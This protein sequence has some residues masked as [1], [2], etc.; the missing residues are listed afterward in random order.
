MGGSADYGS[1]EC[2]SSIC[3][4]SLFGA[5]S[6]ARF[7]ELGHKSLECICEECLECDCE[8]YMW[9]KLGESVM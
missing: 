3:G 1:V 5:R 4:G 8:E 6:V 2:G 7:V 9:E